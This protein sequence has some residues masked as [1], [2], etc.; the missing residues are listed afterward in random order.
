MGADRSSHS[1]NVDRKS[2]A[3]LAT[4][5]SKAAPNR[6]VRYAI[7]VELRI[8]Q[9][10]IGAGA[11]PVQAE[12][13]VGQPCGS[14]AHRGFVGDASVVRRRPGSAVD[15]VAFREPWPPSSLPE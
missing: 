9:V 10:F 13:Q 1:L 8:G 2:L 4:Q 15:A 14:P 6:R 5:C 7:K 11:L 12:D 3:Q